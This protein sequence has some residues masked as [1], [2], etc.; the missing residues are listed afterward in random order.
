MSLLLKLMPI[1]LILQFVL[2]I[3][4]ATLA[5]KPEQLERVKGVLIEIDHAIEELIPE[6]N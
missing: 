4:I 3:I 6:A 1:Q 5:N 2:S